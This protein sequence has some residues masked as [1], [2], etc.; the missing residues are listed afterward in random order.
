MS[1]WYG[2]VY[3]PTP[4]KGAVETEMGSGKLAAAGRPSAAYV[5]NPMYYDLSW[6]GV[7]PKDGPTPEPNVPTC[8]TQSVLEKDIVPSDSILFLG[9]PGGKDPGCQW[10]FP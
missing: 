2:E 7:A 10:P 8:Y 4:Q 9:G 6:F 1:M 5:R 3:N